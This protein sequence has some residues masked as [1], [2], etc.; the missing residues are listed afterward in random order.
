MERFTVSLILYYINRNGP[1]RADHFQKK[2]DKLEYTQKRLIKI[3]ISGPCQ[4]SSGERTG[5]V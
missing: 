5:M 2:F 1:F 3:S 4:M